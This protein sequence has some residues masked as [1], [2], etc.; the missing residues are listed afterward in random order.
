MSTTREPDV[1]RS[2]RMGLGAAVLGLLGLAG[3]AWLWVVTATPIDPPEWLRI[4]GIWLLPIGIVGALVAG[5]PALRGS[6]RALAVVGLVAAGLALVGFV[7]L[8]SFWP[9]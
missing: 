8:I 6:G 4:A 5:I 3:F 9:Y 2:K 1:T 7:L